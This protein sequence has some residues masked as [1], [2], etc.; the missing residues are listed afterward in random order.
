MILALLVLSG[1]AARAQDVARLYQTQAIVTGTGEANRQ[2]G[3]EECLRDAVIKISGDQRLLK[4]PGLAATL[5]QAADYITA[6]RYRDRLEGIPIHDEQGTHDRPHDLFCTLDRAKLD[7]LLKTLGSRPWLAER[8]GLVLFL[9]VEK[10]SKRF[11]L[12]RDGTESPYMR[13]SLLA[14]A[15]PLA[16]TVDVPESDALGAAGISFATL[17]DADPEMLA[18]VT[19]RSGGDLPLVGSLVWSDEELGW[20]ADWRLASKHGTFAWQI[21][22]ISFDDAFR[23]AMSG[24]LQVL[25]GNG[26]PE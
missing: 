5:P 26:Q 25:S 13:D 4:A 12:S 24:A 1:G 16:M 23:N 18:K 11:V 9:S 8:P 3:F 7:V 20:I 22:G 15:E 6:F 21:R 17:G 14:A 10:A 2:L 19:A